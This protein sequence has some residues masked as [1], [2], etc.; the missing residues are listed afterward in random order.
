MPVTLI[1]KEQAICRPRLAGA[2]HTQDMSIEDYWPLFGLSITTDR[3]HLRY[4][5]DS[6]LIELVKVV[7]GAS[8][9]CAQQKPDPGLGSNTREKESEKA[10]G[11]QSYSSPSNA[12]AH[13]W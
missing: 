9:R 5:S 3:L 10:C 8:Q 13:R 1:L 2:S 6:D 7:Q 12:W 4:P 11:R